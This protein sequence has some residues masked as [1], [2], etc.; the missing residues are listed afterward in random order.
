M[1]IIVGPREE[2]FLNLS[3]PDNCLATVPAL[4]LLSTSFLGGKC[5]FAALLELAGN[6]PTILY[7]F[8]L[9]RGAIRENKKKVSV[10]ETHQTLHTTYTPAN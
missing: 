3:S 4:L 6:D 5:T 8:S 9:F 7:S 1:C 2:E 10:Q